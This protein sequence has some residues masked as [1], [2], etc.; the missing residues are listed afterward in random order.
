[1]GGGEGREMEG[2]HGESMRG[3]EGEMSG[4]EREKFQTLGVGR[5]EGINLIIKCEMFIMGP[6]SNLFK[7]IPVF[8][9]SDRIFFLS[10]C[11]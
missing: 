4:R 5:S 6:H 8:S 9:L 11:W 1:M 2:D 7:K 10:Q 3:V